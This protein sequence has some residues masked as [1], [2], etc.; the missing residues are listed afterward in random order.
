MPATTRMQ[1]RICDVLD[2]NSGSGMTPESMTEHLGYKP[3]TK[4]FRTMLPAVAYQME[5]LADDGVIESNGRN[6]FRV[7]RTAVDGGEP[8]NK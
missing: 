3:Q 2:E 8:Q 1:S 5:L 6:V 7:P 4:G